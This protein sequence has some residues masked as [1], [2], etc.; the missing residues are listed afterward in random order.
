MINASNAAAL[1]AKQ[2]QQNYIPTPEVKQ[3]RHVNYDELYPRVFKEPSTNIKFS[4]TV[5]D[6]NPVAYCLREEDVEFLHK[7]NEGRDVDGRERKGA[8]KL[9]QCSE[10]ACEE[11][12]NFF[13]ETSSRLQP[14][15]NLDNAP[16]LTLE[17]M[18]QSIQDD[19]PLS[20][21]AQK[22][23]RPIYDYWLI[24]KAGRPLMASIKVR[25]LDTANEADDADPYVCFRRREVRQTR[26][27]RGRDAQV[28]EKLKKL[29]MELEDGRQLLLSINQREKLKGQ[30]GQLDRKKFRERH[31][32]KKVKAEK[33][34]VGE[35]GD[36]EELLVDQK[37]YAPLSPALTY[38]TDKTSPPQPVTKPGKRQSEANRPATIRLRS[39]GD[40][41]ASVANAQD[42]DLPLLEDYV[43]E[44]AAF[45]SNTIEARK[46]QHRKWNQHW[47]DETKLPITPPLE[48]EDPMSKWAAWPPLLDGLY[49]TPPP[50]LPSRSSVEGED[51]DMKDAPDIK[52]QLDT[53]SGAEYEPEI[54]AIPGAWPE[55]EDDEPKPDKFPAVRLRVGRGGRR[56]LETRKRKPK[57]QLCRGVVS[58]DDSDDGQTPGFFSVPEG[59][60]FELRAAFNNRPTGRPEGTGS[61]QRQ[62]QWGGDQ[63][64]GAAAQGHPQVQQQGA[65]GSAS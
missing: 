16:I 57:G 58:D 62:R 5:E 26:K 35:K 42:N 37:V 45:V 14:F 20:A 48:A 31:Q 52:P 7:L 51:V 53:T 21:E 2:T 10:D 22:W 19:Q 63:Q 49:P 46:E 6:C 11:V 15:A 24:R 33:Q 30:Q 23:L 27:T 38:H 9:S 39:L 18:E 3:A 4:S 13:E 28:T 32:L 55:T 25:V 47:V 40:R 59:I 64:A 12:M 50:S 60:T 41:A 1:G 36:D 56:W 61:E 8:D 17:E 34:I 43:T 44:G 65:A 29:R 54:F